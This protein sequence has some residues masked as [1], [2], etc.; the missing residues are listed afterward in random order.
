[1]TIL[2]HL[3]WPSSIFV[4]CTCDQPPPAMLPC[5]CNVTLKPHD[6]PPAS[7]EPTTRAMSPW[8]C[9]VR[10][11]FR[12]TRSTLTV[13]VKSPPH[14]PTELFTRGRCRFLGWPGPP[15]EPQSVPCSF[16]DP[17]GS[18]GSPRRRVPSHAGRLTGA[19][20]PAA[21]GPCRSNGG[22]RGPCRLP[23]LPVSPPQNGILSNCTRQ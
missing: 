10:L 9:D 12:P 16:R 17:R 7:I 23:P 20:S 18:F 22:K 8:F 11:G 13:L 2:N 21:L 1:M 4:S 14:G 6:A 3:V 19:G 15:G 5:F